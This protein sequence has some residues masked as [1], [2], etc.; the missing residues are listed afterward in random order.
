[1]IPG[2]NQMQLIYQK[3]PFAISLVLQKVLEKINKENNKAYY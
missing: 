1:M 2:F 3:K